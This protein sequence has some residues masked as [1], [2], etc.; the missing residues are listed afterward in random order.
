MAQKN[1]TGA[2]GDGGMKD[3]PQELQNILEDKNGNGSPD[4]VDNPFAAIGKLGDLMALSGKMNPMVQ[5]YI[6][7][8]LTGM[9][10]SAEVINRITGGSL[11]GTDGRLSS[12]G[13]RSQG[14]ENSASSK[15]AENLSASRAALDRLS[16]AGGAVT[17]GGVTPP[18][19]GTPPRSEMPRSTA[20]MQAYLNAQGIRTV[21]SNAGRNFL[22]ILGV[23]AVIGW[24]VWQNTGP[25]FHQ[26][27]G[28]FFKS[29]D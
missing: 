19:A 6:Q 20:N 15:S 18:Q 24:M 14:R 27:V 7:S 10:V 9:N 3:L 23:L 17:L 21:Q 22:F 29:L 26:A 13:D 4:I 25:E 12:A 16:G 5:K 11:Q 1:S 8:K 2:G 28:D